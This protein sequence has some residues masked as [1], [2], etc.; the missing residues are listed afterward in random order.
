MQAKSR[1]QCWL[2]RHPCGV[3]QD[4][5]RGF[6]LTFERDRERAFYPPKQL[7]M[8]TTCGGRALPVHSAGRRRGDA[9]HAAG[10]YTGSGRLMEDIADV[11][12]GNLA[13][14]VAGYPD[15]HPKHNE[16]HVLDALLEKQHLAAG[17]VTQMCFSAPRISW[18]AELLRREGFDLP[19][20]AGV[21]GAV[22][23]TSSSRLPQK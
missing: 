2:F 9:P 12:G 21:A 23:R 20:W 11:T 19:I 4:A 5:G 8:L 7:N 10:P 16:L 15:R 22:P 17:V 1:Q 3:R 13:V 18:Y 6:G 14:G